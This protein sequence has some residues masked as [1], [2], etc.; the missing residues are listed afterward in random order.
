[1]NAYTHVNE[2]EEAVHCRQNALSSVVENVRGREC[3]EAVRRFTV[4][5]LDILDAHILSLTHSLT[6]SLSLLCSTMGDH[7]WNNGFIPSNDNDDDS[8]EYVPS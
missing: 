6:L 5:S 4:L 3:E 7:W 8:K 2:Y 1:M